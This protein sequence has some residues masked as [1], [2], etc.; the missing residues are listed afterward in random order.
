VPAGQ[1]Q[2]IDPQRPLPII[3]TAEVDHD[4]AVGVRDRGRGLVL[5]GG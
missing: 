3:L 2:L 5:A 1:R 4:L